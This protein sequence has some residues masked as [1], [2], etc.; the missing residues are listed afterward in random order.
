MARREINGC[1]VLLTGASS[2][3][4]RALALELA[5]AGAKQVLVARQ[6]D[7]LEEVRSEIESLGG[8]AAVCAGDV[9]DPTV[10]QIALE[11]CRDHYRGI[12]VL[13]N[14]AGVGGLGRFDE[15]SP[16]RLQQIINV[17]FVAVAE[18]TRATLPDLREG[19]NPLI[20]NMGSILGHRG[21]PFFSEYCA[22][23]FALRG[24][25]ESLRPELARDG[26]DMLL[27]TPGSTDTE[28][29]DNAIDGRKP[30]PWAR[31][32]AVSAEAVAVATVR[33]M[34][35]GK[36]EIIPNTQGRML[37]WANRLCPWLVDRM[38]VKYVK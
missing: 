13:I 20:V 31:S 38:M 37:V 2:G 10:C 17:N 3:I 34:R 16:E 22:S 23:K 24:F 7:K 19:S 9:T 26:V 11:R 30:L 5:R 28:F 33:A 1:R 35:K 6:L 27:V 12:D 32:G 36:R 25:H 14:N 29:Y 8:E 15:A 18:W 21:I 4:G